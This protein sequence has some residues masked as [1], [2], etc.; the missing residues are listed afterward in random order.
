[1]TS[2]VIAVLVLTDLVFLA[3]IVPVVGIMHPMYGVRSNPL[4]VFANPI[5][6]NFLH[7]SLVDWSQRR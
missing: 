1:M 7:S 5:P 6:F 3:F 2:V 4:S